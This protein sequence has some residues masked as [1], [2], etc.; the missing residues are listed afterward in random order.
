MQYAR[1]GLQYARSAERLA[2]QPVSVTND[3]FAL[4]LGDHSHCWAWSGCSLGGMGSATCKERDPQNR[5][6]KH[7]MSEATETAAVGSE[8][9]PI[10]HP[11]AG[12]RR[13]VW[14]AILSV[15]LLTLVTGA[16]FPLVLAVLARP[17]FPY[18]SEGSLIS[19]PDGVIGSALLGQSFSQPGYF[20]PR[21]S[22]AGDGYDATASGGTNYG[23]SNPKFREGV[24]KCVADYRRENDLS[25][26]TMVPIDAV[27]HSGSGLDPHI[28]LANAVLQAPRVARVRGLNV[29]Q[30]RQMI[31]EHTQDRQ[32]G[33]LGEVRVSVLP[34]NLALDR[35]A[36]LPAPQAGR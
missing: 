4:R 30:V 5:R 34:L 29:A 9:S 25:A 20:H 28:S 14:P 17:L 35:I 36:P 32:F 1:P 2:E 27:T 21:L 19:G 16:G 8:P 10:P 7:G 23:P 24:R 12:L 26:E 11:L 3:F 15:P 31:A 22:A 18:Q 13:Q 6:R 33:V